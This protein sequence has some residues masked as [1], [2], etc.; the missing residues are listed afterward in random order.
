MDGGIDK[1]A[2]GNF[3]LNGI[4]ELKDSQ[5]DL[6]KMELFGVWING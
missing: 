1:M 3:L 4:R 5:V 2:R 6:N